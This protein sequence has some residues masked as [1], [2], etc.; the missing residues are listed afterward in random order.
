MSS[1]TYGERANGL[2]EQPVLAS[3]VAR[4]ALSLSEPL[5]LKSTESERAKEPKK[6]LQGASQEAESAAE[7]SEPRNREEQEALVSQ[8]IRRA[9]P[10]SVVVD[11]AFCQCY[12]P[13]QRPTGL[14]PWEGGEDE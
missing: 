3:H 2:E 10:T 6:H 13:P 5:S 12:T 7:R 1:S 11:H 14:A 9:A 8:R 4:R